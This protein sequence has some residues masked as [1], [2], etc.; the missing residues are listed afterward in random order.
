MPVVRSFVAIGVS[1]GNPH[2]VTRVAPHSIIHAGINPPPCSELQWPKF[3]ECMSVLI[4]KKEGMQ[5]QFFRRCD[6]SAEGL[7]DCLR[8]D[9]RDR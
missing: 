2:T 8:Q 5:S 1:R 4:I 3:V 9:S 6:L 7:G